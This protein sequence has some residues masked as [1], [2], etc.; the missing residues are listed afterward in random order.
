M[1]L[2]VLIIAVMICSIS[3]FASIAS[4]KNTT[5][6]SQFFVSITR[7]DDEESIFKKSMYISGEKVVTDQIRVELYMY[8]SISGVYESYSNTDGE[9][10]WDI[11]SSGK[12]FKEVN[13]SSEGTY[14]I[15]I[16]AYKKSESDNL[17]AGTNLQISDYTIKVLN[18]NM[19]D[20]IKD[21]IKKGV[22]KITDGL[23]DLLN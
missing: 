22:T 18:E 15:R 14:K 8:N 1:V 20:A 9:N 3:S 13:F 2:P 21:S 7:P 4:D 10:A 19:K 11:G 17:Q 5:E 12:F 16:A 23:K 6:T